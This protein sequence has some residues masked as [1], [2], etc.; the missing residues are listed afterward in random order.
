MNY[1]R[2]LMV[3]GSVFVLVYICTIGIK[4]IVR[5]NGFSLEYN[6]LVLEYE[7]VKEKQRRFKFILGSIQKDGH[8]ELLAKE[9]LGYVKK[10]EKMIKFINE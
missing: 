10:N 2:F 6:N 4:N 9:R 7:Q 5:Y 1:F 3:L 8:I